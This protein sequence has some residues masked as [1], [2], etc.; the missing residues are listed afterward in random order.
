[1]VE[2]RMGGDTLSGMTLTGQ[3]PS[4]TSASGAF[5]RQAYAIRDR[6]TADG[7]SGFRA[8]PGRYHLYVSLACPWAHRA[9]IVRRLL[10]LEAV[11]SMSVV[12]P[13]RDER[14]WAFRDGPGHGPDPRERPS[15]ARPGSDRRRTWK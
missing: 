15:R 2:H 8:E 14:G 4:E 13:I 3:F 6:I 12:D 10:G 11:I 7:S 5:V 9:I 1:M